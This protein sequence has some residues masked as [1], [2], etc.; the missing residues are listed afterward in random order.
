MKQIQTDG[1]SWTMCAITWLGGFM[2]SISQSQILF[3]LTVV[4]GV[5]SV[6]YNLVKIRKELKNK[7]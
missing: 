2:Q 1:A 4:S 7:K 3:T 5:T 6:V